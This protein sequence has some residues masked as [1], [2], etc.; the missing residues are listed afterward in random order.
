[1]SMLRTPILLLLL[2]MGLTVSAAA[3][4]VDDLTAA[5]QGLAKDSFSETV[6]VVD[7][8]AASG[9]DRAEM[10]LTALKQGNLYF[11]TSDQQAYIKDGDALTLAATGEPHQGDVPFG[12]KKV[13]LN[14][15]V[16]SS[17]DAAMGALQLMAHDPA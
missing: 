9:S 12:L 13:R 16:R 3:A 6:K 8:V 1:M 4:P 15:L 2:L 7:A 11:A 14:N 17:L 5:L 10:I